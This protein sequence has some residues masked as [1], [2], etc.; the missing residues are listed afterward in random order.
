[1]FRLIYKLVKGIF[2]VIGSIIGFIVCAVV[3]IIIFAFLIRSCSDMV[4]YHGP[5]EHHCLQT[6]Y[7][8]QSGNRYNTQPQ[9][10]T[11]FNYNENRIGDASYMFE[12]YHF[13]H[14]FNPGVLVACPVCHKEFHK[15]SIDNC[16][17]SDACWCTYNDIVMAWNRNDRYGVERLGKRFDKYDH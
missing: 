4:S 9:R 8:E 6:E 16:F 3:G 15:N 5:D 7:F 10:Y 13:I 14:Q 11:N 17:C 12:E 1:M 2:G